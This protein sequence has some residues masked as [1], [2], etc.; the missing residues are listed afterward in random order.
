[1]TFLITTNNFIDTFLFPWQR[2]TKNIYGSPAKQAN[3]N[4]NNHK[5][6]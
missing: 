4:K 3:L 2:I 1:M 5:D 6:S